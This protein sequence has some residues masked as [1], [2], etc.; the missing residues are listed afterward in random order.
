MRYEKIVVAVAVEVA[1][2]QPHRTAILFHPG[3]SARVDKLAVPVEIELILRD[4]VG[5][6]EIQP[7]VAVEVVPQR[8]EA[9]ALQ[10]GDPELPRHFGEGAIAVVAKQQ[11]A[12]GLVGSG[13]QGERHFDPELLRALACP[14]SV[15][16]GT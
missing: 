16:G 14:G 7:A 9:A 11:V 5:Y 12:L 13:I 2:G 8:A 15:S 4:V 6:V 1:G 3:T 10:V